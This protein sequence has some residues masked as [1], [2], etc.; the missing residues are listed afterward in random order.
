[1][2]LGIAGRRAAVAAASRG[3]GRATALALAAEGAEVVICGRDAA[4]LDDALV[5][6]RGVAPDAERVMAMR[7]DVSNASGAREFADGATALLGGIDI[8]VVNGGGPPAGNFASTPESAYRPALE[9]NLLSV[10][11]MCEATVPAMCERGWGRVLAIT[12][13]AVRQP[14]PHLILSN[15]ARA[16]AT[17]FLK[18]LALEVAPR[19]VTVNTIQPGVHR[20]DRMRALYGEAIESAAA[21]VPAGVL[22]EPEDFGAVAAFMCSEHARFM[23]GVHLQIDGGAT[24]A[25]L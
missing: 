22:G 19:G 16:G 4:V 18:T 8:L 2:D 5:A 25:L 10:V 3:L 17:A 14:V 12:S 1:M 15:T 24:R 13:Y 23:T 6:L 20:T 11:A 7:G 21:D 9:A